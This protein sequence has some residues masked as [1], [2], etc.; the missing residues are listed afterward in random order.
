MR[1]FTAAFEA[2]YAALPLD[3][4]ID[5][6]GGVNG[7][8]MIWIVRGIGD[9]LLRT[10]V[11]DHSRVLLMD[12]GRNES[13]LDIEDARYVYQRRKEDTIDRIESRTRID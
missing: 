5:K 12:Q 2:L 8:V 7:E 6:S 13:L 3:G 1:D 10:G 9:S 4:S 11:N